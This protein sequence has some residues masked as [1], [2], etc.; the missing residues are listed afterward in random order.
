MPDEQKWY[1]AKGGVAYGP[2]SQHEL[3]KKFEDGFFGAKDFVYCK[4]ATEGWV[5]AESIP[6]LCDTLTLE[7]EP[8]PEHHEVP[9]YEKAAYNRA[10]GE[11]R[12]KKAHEQREKQLLN[13]LRKK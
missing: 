4:E 13:K 11:D 6:G 1:F 10:V 9:L 5:A 2:Y 3:C 8:E 7:P 12:V